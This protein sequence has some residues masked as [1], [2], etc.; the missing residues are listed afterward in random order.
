MYKLP[1]KWYLNTDGIQTQMIFCFPYIFDQ[2]HGILILCVSVPIIR[3]QL[4]GVDTNILKSD[5]LELRNKENTIS[6]V[7]F[8]LTYFT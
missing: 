8:F 5:A 2:E 1:T 3:R 7:T 6:S 4:W